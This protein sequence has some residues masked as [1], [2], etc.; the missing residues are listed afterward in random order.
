[1]RKQNRKP[2]IT[3]D[4]VGRNE[5]GAGAVTPDPRL[6]TIARALGR[7]IAREEVNAAKAPSIPDRR[8]GRPC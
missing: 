3:R 2:G 6:V 8:T 7:L 4:A 5:N 1:M